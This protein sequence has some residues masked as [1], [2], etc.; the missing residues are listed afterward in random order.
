M[1]PVL[2]HYQ[3]EALLTARKE[4][5]GVAL[6]SADLNL[7]RVEVRLEDEGVLFP[8]GEWVKWIELEEMC[9]NPNGCYR[10][11]E[12]G[13]QV[14]RGFSELTGRSFSLYPTKSAPTMLISGLPMHRIKDTNPYLDTREKIRA[15]A[16]V[17]GHVLD[18]A[19]GLGYTAI[20]AAH[21]A[22]A[23]V[24]IE[25]DPLSLEMASANP[26][27]R[28]LFEDKR[29]RQLLGDSFEEIEQ[30]EDGSFSL[31]LHDPPV[32]ALGGDLY[33][34]EFYRKTWRVLKPRGRMFHYIGDPDS[35]SGARITR[36]VVQRLITAGFREVI[37][38]RRAFGVMALK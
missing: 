6:I 38:A 8:G 4:T 27:S 25:L 1:N 3:A 35:K 18:T 11:T 24:T 17:R 34:E 28:A 10:L 31:I 21:T 22:E 19:T 26:W 7:T 29:I 33:S 16:P 23:V 14:V 15:A 12:A 36:G 20:E 37:P 2:S 5:A 32:F 9:A 13:I 30:F